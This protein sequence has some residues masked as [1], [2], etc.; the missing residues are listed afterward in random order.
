MSPFVAPTDSLGSVTLDLDELDLLVHLLA[1]DELPV[2]LD[3][4]PRFDSAAARDAAFTDA[5]ESL[6]GRG[7]L[8]AG[9]P[10][11]DVADWL[12]L[13][14]RPSAEIALRW[15]TTGQAEISRLCLVHGT[16]GEL[17]A[18]RG[19]NSYVLQPSEGQGPELLLDAVGRAAPLDFG[20]V[21]APTDL[22]IGA[23]EDCANRVSTARRLT[24]IGVTEVDAGTLAAALAGRRA[25]AEIVGI[26]HADA[27]VTQVGGPVT[28][29]HTDRG[30]IV[31][32]SSVSADGVAWTTLS[33]GTD[34]RLRRAIADLVTETG[35]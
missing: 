16:A 33:P 10:H 28:V 25:H 8:P 9:A 12:A 26:R 20:P 29:F 13:L 27:A 30:R 31:G 19:P 17:L 3:A 23:L 21:N 34:A 15:Y 6:T 24:E 1:V 18:L 2:V 14:A 11:P 22:L 4:G 32:T 7:L 35:C 5:Q